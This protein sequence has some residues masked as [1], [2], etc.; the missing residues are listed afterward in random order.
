MKPLVGTLVVK[1]E[2]FFFRQS[3]YLV[4]FKGWD[5]ECRVVDLGRGEERERTVVI[6]GGARAPER[7]GRVGEVGFPG[8]VDEVVVVEAEAAAGAAGRVEPVDVAFAGGD[9]EPYVNG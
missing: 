8:E 2:K 4:D 3:E 1:T 9:G 6:R 5:G 7:H